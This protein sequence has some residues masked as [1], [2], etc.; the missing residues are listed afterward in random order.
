[1]E[2]LL[3]SDFDPITYTTGTV[4][5]TAGQNRTDIDAG[6]KFTQPQ[7]ASVGDRVWLDTNGDGI[8]DAGEPGV[9]NVLV[10][11]YNSSGVAVAVLI[12]MQMDSTCL[13][14]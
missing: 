2:I 14:M 7:P 11:L 1:M 9:S 13:Q 10:T 8:Q 6:L 3:D 5:L 12:Q 4:T